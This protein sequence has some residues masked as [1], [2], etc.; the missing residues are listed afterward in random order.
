VLVAREQA[1]IALAEKT[2]A[3]DLLLEKKKTAGIL[4][5]S[6][7]EMPLSPRLDI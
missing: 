4:A 2:R 1:Q 7:S 5:V 6:L 3:E